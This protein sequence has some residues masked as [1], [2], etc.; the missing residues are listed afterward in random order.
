M[1]DEDIGITEDA[2]RACVELIAICPAQAP[3]A[4]PN[5]LQLVHDEDAEVKL[6]GL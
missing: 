1:S 4:V 5:I 2:C 6:L 3:T